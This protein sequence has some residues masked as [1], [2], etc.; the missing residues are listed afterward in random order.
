MDSQ[1]GKIS[2]PV[3]GMN[4]PGTW[5][6]SRIAQVILLSN[7]AGLVI[8]IIG[9]LLVNEVR[10][11]LV[12]ARMESLES[13]ALSYEGMLSSIATGTEPEPVLDVRASN[14]LLKRWKVPRSTRVRIFL[15]GGETAVDTALLEDQVE[16][17]DLPSIVEPG[18]ID[19]VSVGI[20]RS[21]SDV[22]QQIAPHGGVDFIEARSLD[23][24][25]YIAFG[26][27]IAASQR[28]SESGERLISVSVPVQ[29]VANVIAVM[30][31]EASDVQDV[32]RA[33]RAAL[34]PIIGVAVL[35]ALITS[36]LLTIFIA[37][38]LRRLA[39][40]ADRVRTGVAERFDLPAMSQRK[41]E[42][43]ELAKALEA[44][45]SALKDRIELNERFAA[46]V[47]HELKNPLTSIRSA[48]DTASHVNDP[49]LQARM[50]EVIAKDVIRLD[51]LITDISNASRLEAEIARETPG[52]VDLGRLLEDLG[53]IW[54]DTRRDGEPEVSLL[55][56]RDFGE[57][58]VTGRE[59]P[60]SQVIRNLVEN[61]RSFCPSD[62]VVAINGQRMGDSIVISIE[63]DGPGIPSDKLEKIF[64]R[65]YS[66]RPKGAKF[67]NNSGLGLSIVKQIVE[68]HRG[69][70][71]A[72]N[73]KDGE[74]V[75]GA[76]FVVSLPVN[77]TNLKNLS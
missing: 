34:V 20:S 58:V 68:T 32:I 1:F 19:R 5:V 67:G 28:F 61:A 16:E 46:D 45:T 26:G 12:Q 40:A 54:R 30:T 59:G 7:L 47:A 22:V 64:D 55:I 17:R 65:F 76:K 24:E 39:I 11:G 18:L 37:R 60:L 48:V 69:R 38:P 21:L 75:L 52:R 70:V 73:R 41:D 51:R 3:A 50:R 71:W 77:D 23:E 66:D 29:R 2:K 27:D 8:L 74:R 25:H 57:L 33:E 44:M 35:V 9:A 10:A 13:T 31:V 42:M 53:S 72:E 4:A 63:D 56:D 6:K 49:K 15:P 62:G 36:G 14:F 43:G